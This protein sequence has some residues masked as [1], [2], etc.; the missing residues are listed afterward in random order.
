MAFDNAC[1][2]NL[3][4]IKSFYYILDPFININD[5]MRCFKLK[6]IF[7]KLNLF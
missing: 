3:P 7:V 5:V 6:I 2:T 1:K 4:K